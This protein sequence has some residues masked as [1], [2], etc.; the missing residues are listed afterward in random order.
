MPIDILPIL[1]ALSSAF[2]FALAIQIMHVGLKYTDPE[3]GSLLHIAASCLFYWLLAP[4]FVSGEMWLTWAT[5]LFAAVG[6]FRPALSANLA[7]QAVQRIGPTLTSA[8][9]AISPLFGI[10]FGIVLLGEVMTLPIAAGTATIMTGLLVLARGRPVD[11]GWPLWA[12]ALPL[13]AALVRAAAHT[14]TKIGFA[15]VDS[16]FFA[17]LVGYTVSLTVAYGVHR[18]RRRTVNWRVR[19]LGWFIAA[20]IVNGISV[21]CLNTA[22]R[23]GDIITVVPIV[24][25]SPFAALLLSV[26]IFRRETITPRSVITIFLIVPG[27]VLIAVAP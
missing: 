27:V 2:L 13:G 19:G 11:A 12:L 10:V 9:T 5:L 20:G 7:L 8:L 16:A 26:V 21:F 23:L 1:L 4:A 15:A 17:A 25:C 3:T 22:L 24:S 6:I 18:S 14:F